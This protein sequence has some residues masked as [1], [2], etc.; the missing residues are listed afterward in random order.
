MFLRFAS[1]MGPKPSAAPSA[2]DL[3]REARAAEDWIHHVHSFQVRFD[4]KLTRTPEGLAHS[5]A[6]LAAR[7]P[8]ADLD[9]GRFP[10]L[11][12]TSSETLTL[13][14]DDHRLRKEQNRPDYRRDLRVWDGKLAVA[15]EDYT[16]T[17]QEHYALRDEPVSM[18]GKFILVDMRWLHGSPH[19]FWWDETSYK[20]MEDNY[21]KPGEWTL[22]KQVPFH[23]IDCHVLERRFDSL[24]IGVED[25]RI[26]GFVLRS[27]TRE[28]AD[29]TEARRRLAVEFGAAAATAPEIDRWYRGLGPE[30]REAYLDA[31]HKR[32]KSYARPLGEDFLTDY[33][34]IVPGCWFPMRQVCT[35]YETDSVGKTFA[36]ARVELR[37]TEVKINEPLADELFRIEMKEGVKVID[38]RY[39]PFLVYKWK[40]GMTEAEYQALIEAREKEEAP[41]REAKAKQD[42]LIGRPALPFPTE[43]AWLNSQPRTWDDLRGKVVILDFWA[44]WCGPCRSDLPRMCDL[45]KDR[46]V[47]GITAIGVH[48]PGSEPEAID[49]VMKEFGI[50]Y[51]VCIDIAEENGPETWGRLA[52][53]DYHVFG[54]PHAF[55][56]DR[57]GKIAGHGSLN[58]VYGKAYKLA[59]QPVD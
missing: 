22:I 5:R 59:S 42:A 17:D 36:S 24:Y 55:V 38:R 35:V 39:D 8:N 34:E 56:I 7:F 53:K 4:V 3:V 2:E 58:E 29:L 25:H 48:N 31:F 12:P 44:E 21:G 43:S 28:T 15:H 10:E 23:G 6:E 16:Q 30:D 40:A 26:H 47:N 20:G 54:I 19:H 51:P 32:L 9:S 57:T 33:R 49:K 11:N 14:F 45:H 13:M 37:A 18:I 1:T 52:M 50:E 41:M 46:E 27:F